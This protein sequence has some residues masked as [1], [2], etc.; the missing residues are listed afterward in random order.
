MDRRTGRP[1][2]TRGFGSYQEIGAAGER[3]FLLD[4]KAAG[5]V[6]RVF[7]NPYDLQISIVGA[8]YGAQKAAVLEKLAGIALRRLAATAAELPVDSAGER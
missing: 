8:G 3:A 5:A 7:R 2:A 6:L 4:R 1:D